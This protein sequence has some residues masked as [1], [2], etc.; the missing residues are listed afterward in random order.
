GNCPKC[1]F[2][3]LI[4]AP[5]MPKTRLI[6]IFGQDLLAQPRHERSFRELTGLAGQKPWECVGEIEEAAVC[7]HAL[8]D[9]PEW[10]D[11]PIVS[12][13]KPDLLKLYVN[14]RLE[15]ALAEL[16]TDMTEHLIP[17]DI[18]RRVADHAL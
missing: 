8:T 12:M 3:F 5:V 15:A 7:L 17:A 1:H 9:M 13:L 18:A 14:A 2:V 16:L 10:A 11:A 4:I 6:G